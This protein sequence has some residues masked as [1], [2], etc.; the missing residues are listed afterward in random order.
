MSEQERILDWQKR[1]SRYTTS[2][3]TPQTV[4]ED[5]LGMVADIF[6]QLTPLE[7][8]VMQMRGM[9]GM[10]HREIGKIIWPELNEGAATGRSTHAYGRA[11][12]KIR[13]L[14][15]SPEKI[16]FVPEEKGRKL[17]ANGLGDELAELVQMVIKKGKGE[18]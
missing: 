16:E 8:R 15:D 3:Q 13:M 18:R 1:N 12:K 6:S 14:V 10:R 2:N 11:I 7:Q 5:K 17:I 9:S 4:D